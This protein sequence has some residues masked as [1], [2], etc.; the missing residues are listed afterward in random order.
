MGVLR[1]RRL[2]RIDYDQRH[3]LAPLGNADAAWVVR[4]SRTAVR[5]PSALRRVIGCDDGG[6]SLSQMGCQLSTGPCG[7]ACAG[8]PVW[9][10]FSTYLRNA[11][12]DPRDF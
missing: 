11:P 3:G 8:G 1:S 5:P 6:L 9:C 7:G 2:I 12:L 10:P 4:A